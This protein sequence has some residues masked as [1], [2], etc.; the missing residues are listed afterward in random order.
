MSGWRET[1]FTTA[2]FRQGQGDSEK[3]MGMMEG[4]LREE[5]GSFQLG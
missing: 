5:E 4:G 2:E 3:G 1:R